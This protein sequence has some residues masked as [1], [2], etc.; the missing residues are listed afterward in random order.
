M[1]RIV[2]QE[3]IDPARLSDAEVEGWINRLYPAHAEIFDGVS[4]EEFA[5]YVVRS[6]AERT[7]IQV[8]FGEGDEVAG[9]VAAHAFHRRFRGEVCMVFRAEAGL[10]RA[11]RGDGS[12]GSFLAS[13]ILR[14]WLESPGRHYYLGCLVHPSSYISIA[15]VVPELWPAPGVEAPAD[16]AAFMMELGE[17]FHLEMVDPARP[18][19]R[20]VGWITADTEV[21][22]QYWRTCDN[23]L[24]RFY[25]EQNP[26]YFEG[27]GLLTLVP[28]DALSM[29]RTIATLGTA[30]VQKRLKR[31]LGALERNVLRPR[32]DEGQAEGLLRRLEEKT[33]LT[34]DSVR[35]LGIVGRRYPIAAKTA[36]IRAGE[37]GDD[38]YAVVSGSLLVV[39]E[40]VDGAEYVIDQLGPGQVVGELAVL[41]GQPRTAT[42]RAAVDSVLIKLGPE[43]LAKLTEA[44]PELEQ[45]MWAYVASRIVIT[46][47]G[48]RP[49]VPRKGALR[50]SW[51][52]AGRHLALPRGE[53][54]TVTEGEPRLVV[55]RG[56]VSLEGSMGWA[57][58]HAPAT[59]RCPAGTVIA[60][61]EDA[62]VSL[63]P[64]PPGG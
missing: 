60:A 56:Q 11:W 31:T 1:A 2:R 14:T 49:G 16:V 38:L 17:E 46:L 12:T 33:G 27:T 26:T 34:L 48:C 3:I 21:E 50:E 40:G 28:L 29:G 24:A 13:D 5:R 42:V 53:R 30:G 45:V 32:L 19:V 6:P 9:Y 39:G 41:T 18:L 43:D 47:S 8:M 44:S 52:Q 22:R 51:L 54:V 25:I 7:R 57:V 59:L 64:E 35:E 4:R 23:H 10:R 61:I 58:L 37:R 55:A 63:L 62:R 15:R 20:K 36:L